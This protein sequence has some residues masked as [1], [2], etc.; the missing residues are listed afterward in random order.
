VS[1]TRIDR[2]LITY[3][4]LD[5]VVT[6]PG[7]GTW[8]VRTRRWWSY[9]PGKGLMFFRK[10]PQCNVS[11]A[12]ARKVTEQCHPGAEVIFMPRVCLRHDC[13]DYV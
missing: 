8:D 10:S 1:G 6:E 3:L 7:D 4:P 13:G 11:E 9:E 12:V 5:K 2:R